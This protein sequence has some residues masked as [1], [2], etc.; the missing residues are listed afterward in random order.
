MATGAFA[1]RAQQQRPGP[2]RI[3]RQQQMAGT[4]DVFGA[5]QAGSGRTRLPQM[6]D[7]DSARAAA[8]R[9]DRAADKAEQKGDA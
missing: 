5:P 8:N 3:A 1:R 9:G 7:G 4:G 6:G 2:D